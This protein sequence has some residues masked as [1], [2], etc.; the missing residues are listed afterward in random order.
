MH[1]IRTVLI[2]WIVLPKMDLTVVR[3]TAWMF[4]VL[5]QMKITVILMGRLM[6][7]VQM[8][9]TAP[10]LIQVTVMNQTAMMDIQTVITVMNLPMNKRTTDIL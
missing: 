3:I 7:V 1:R 5:E 2:I 8:V 9:I 10:S 4:P 6:T